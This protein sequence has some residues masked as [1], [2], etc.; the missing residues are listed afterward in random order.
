MRREE[1]KR[2]TKLAITNAAFKLFSENGY[3]STKVEDIVKLAGVSKGTFFNYFPTKEA[4]IEDF[5]RIS[6]YSEAEKL[7]NITSPVVPK[8]LSSLI[9][10]VHNLNYTRSLRRATLMAT[11]SSANNLNDHMDNMNNLRALLIPIFKYGQETGEFT[12]KLPPETLADLTIQ[13]FIGVLTHWCL[14]GGEDDLITQLMMSFDV[15]FKGIS[16]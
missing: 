12:Q 3:E 6:I 8:L 9:N 2:Q 13:M 11:L 7:M 4:V 5:E 1:K 10:I 14:G 15:F 16:S